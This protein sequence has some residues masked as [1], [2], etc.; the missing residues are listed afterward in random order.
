MSHITKDDL[1]TRREQFK[2]FL[3]RM[4]VHLARFGEVYRQPL[5]AISVEV[6]IEQ[7]KHLTPEQLDAACTRAIATSEFMPV[8]ATVLRCHNEITAATHDGVFLGPRMIDYKGGAT[9]EEREEAL[10]FSEKLKETLGVAPVPGA[11]PAKKNR[12]T[13]VRSPEEQQKVLEEQLKKIK[14]KK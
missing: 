4:K 6:Y 13:F 8:P 5:T 2:K 3:D 11:K 9:K 1:T 7:L 10:K 12:M 14:E